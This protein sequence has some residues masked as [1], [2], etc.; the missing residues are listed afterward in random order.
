[1]KRIA[2]HEHPT[3][4]SI[5]DVVSVAVVGIQPL[6]AIVIALDIEDVEVAIRVGCVQN[7]FHVTVP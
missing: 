1:M 6:L 7:A 4:V 2:T 5:P 3:V